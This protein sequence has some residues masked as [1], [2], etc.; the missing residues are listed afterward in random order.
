MN[1]TIQDTRKGKLRY[2]RNCFP[3][4]GYTHNYGASPQTWEGPKETHPET[5][6]VGDNDP[7]DV[8]EIGES[9]A[10]IGEIK[11]VKILGIMALLDEGETDWKVV[12]I[13]IRDLLAPKLNE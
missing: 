13:D 9:I 11:Q 4:H 5:K 2:V 6:A 1:P 12:T 8:L 7:L 10:Y 3:R